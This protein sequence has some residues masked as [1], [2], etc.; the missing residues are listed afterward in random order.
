M[1]FNLTEEQIELKEA[2]RNFAQNELT[3]LAI[4]L[5]ESV[6]PVPKEVLARI[7]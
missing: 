1:D 4:E 3:D 6:S 5:E 7:G 2:A